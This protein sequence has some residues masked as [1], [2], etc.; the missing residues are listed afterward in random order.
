MLLAPSLIFF[1][2]RAVCKKVLV[3]AGCACCFGLLGLV[4]S[5]WGF[6]GFSYVLR[7]EKILNNNNNNSN[8]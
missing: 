8:K 3:T 6:L 5:T 4:Q 2:I 7:L 1:T